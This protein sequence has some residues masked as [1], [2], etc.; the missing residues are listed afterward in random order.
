M[1]VCKIDPKILK[2]S[3]S[4]LEY[5]VCCEQGTEPPFQ[6]AYWDNKAAGIYRCKCCKTPLFSSDDKFDSGTG[7]PSFTRPIKK[8]SLSFHRDKSFA[9]ERIELRCA[10]CGCHLGHLFS[11]GPAPSYERYCI[12]SASLDFDKS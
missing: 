6:N 8:D 5:H 1:S 3:L 2:E 10:E 9:L 4:P 11:D 7:W 12:N